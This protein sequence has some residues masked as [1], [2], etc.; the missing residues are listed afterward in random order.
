MSSHLAMSLMSAAEFVLSAVLAFLFWKKGMYRRFPAMGAYLA[1]RVASTP[2]LFLLLSGDMIFRW[3]MWLISYFY[4]FW[5]VYI[6]SAVLLF[7]V[8]IEVFRSALSAFSGLM[9]F[10]IVIFRWAVLASVIVTFSSISFAHRGILIIP[11]IGDGLMRSVSIL[12]LCLLGFL[13]LSMNA[14][15]ISVRD[16]AFGIALGFG[17]MSAN[18]FVV[19]SLISHNTSLTAPLQFVYQSVVLVSLGIWVAYCAAPEPARKPVVM[20]ANSTIYRWNE[21]ASA[22]GHTGTQVAVQQP[23]NSFFLTDV[24]RVVEKVLNRSLKGRESEL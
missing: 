6:A 18:D 16:M 10:G 1:L 22:L 12:E 23:A 2:V 15:R 19:V 20:P 5:A 17:V 13:C 7:F 14:L 8:C 9:K 3:Q 11:D 24:E 4:L 21:I